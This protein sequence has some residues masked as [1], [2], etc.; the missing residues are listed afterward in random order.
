MLKI[1]ILI[2]IAASRAFSNNQQNME[3]VFT[4]LG[5]DLNQDGLIELSDMIDVDNGVI[6]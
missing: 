3:G 2:S 5:G 6:L 4:I 1:F